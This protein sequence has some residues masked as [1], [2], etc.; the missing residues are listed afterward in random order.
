MSKNE[1]TLIES[2]NAAEEAANTRA[3]RIRD[4]VTRLCERNVE[5][6]CNLL[7]ADDWVRLAEHA[8]FEPRSVEIIRTRFLRLTADERK[9][10]LEFFL[11]D[12]PAIHAE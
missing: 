9:S 6:F 12:T 1:S 11:W 2:L 3:E 4:W 5:G 8:C 10:I 7:W